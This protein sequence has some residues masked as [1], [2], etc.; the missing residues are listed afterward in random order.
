MNDTSKISFIPKGSLAREETFLERPRPRSLLGFFATF[1]FL[2][3]V[4][5]YVGLYFYND[6]LTGRI[7][8]LAL[9][10]QNIQK[11]FEQPEIAQARVFRA[12]AGLVQKLLNEH[13]VVTPIFDFLATN[14]AES[15]FYHDLKFAR[16]E[17]GAL[18]LEVSGEAPS[19]TSLAYQADV[20]RQ[21]DEELLGFSVD[22]IML[23]KTGSVSFVFNMTFVPQYLLYVKLHT[24]T[25]DTGLISGDAP[26]LPAISAEPAKD[27]SGLPDGGS[28][29]SQSDATTSAPSSVGSGA[30]AS[31]ET[32]CEEPLVSKVLDDG[33]TI[34]VERETS[35]LED[36][37]VSF[38]SWFKFW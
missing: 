18:S 30:T 23:T 2:A 4:G 32:Q 25:S 14:T 37:Q 16:G 22:N 3:S 24:A 13:I 10:V 7:N 33:R 11:D 12:R 21:K 17:K 5:S 19:Y 8:G 20:F 1:V 35:G 26:S 27:V 15:V 28:T 6:I 29:V 38:W 36:S 34:C 31:F 9:H